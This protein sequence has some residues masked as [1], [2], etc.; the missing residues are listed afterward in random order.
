MDNEK[1]IRKTSVMMYA[2]VKKLESI[3]KANE[4]SLDENVKGELKNVISN[5]TKAD[6]ELCSGFNVKMSNKVRE[7][8]IDFL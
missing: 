7:S 4:K 6:K 8:I 5:L 2:S 3:L 1:L